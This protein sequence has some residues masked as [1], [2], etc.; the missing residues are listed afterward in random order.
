M[1]AV[2]TAPGYGDSELMIGMSG[3]GTPVH[4]KLSPETAPSVSV[5]RSLQRIRRDRL[6][7]VQLHDPGL[8]EHDPHG[9]ID[10]SVDLVGRTIGALGVSIY[11]ADD[12]DRAT[13]DARISIVQL[14]FSVADQRLADRLTGASSAGTVVVARSAFLQGALLLEPKS[15]P[16]HLVALR[17]VI[18]RVDHVAAGSGR[19]RY[20]TLVVFVRDTPGVTN[21]VL[22][23]ETIDQLEANVAAFA[24]A[25][26]TAVE[27]GVLEA[28]A[29]TEV[30][31]VDPRLWP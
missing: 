30:T 12:F 24:A 5:S 4:S 22:G 8:L 6:E 11:T 19:T 13:T 20:E 1:G 9:V 15:L 18:E 7:V 2:D 25:P 29:E 26:L 31:V 28:C 10:A 17:S 23:C 27:R 14:P 21:V 16:D 3:I